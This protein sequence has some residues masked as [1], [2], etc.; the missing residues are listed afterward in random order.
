MSLQVLVAF[1][2][3]KP[4][5]ITSEA[6]SS[7]L[8]AEIDGRSVTILTPKLNWGWM[9]FPK[10]EAP[11]EFVGTPADQYQVPG[12][13][14]EWG[15]VL[16][17][18]P[19]NRTVDAL[20]LQQV[21]VGIVDSSLGGL[22]VLG[23]RAFVLN[24]WLNHEL[25]PW[26]LALSDWIEIWTDRVGSSQARNHR[27][28]SFGHG[29]AT[30]IRKCGVWEGPIRT[31]EQSAA[32]PMADSIWG[33]PAD[34]A[35]IQRALDLVSGGKIPDV[36]DLFRRDAREGWVAGKNR[37]AVLDAGLASEL[38]LYETYKKVLA[39][40][41]SMA[42]RRMPNRD[43]PTLGDLVRLLGA[44][45]VDLP[46]ELKTRLVDPRNDATHR[47]NQTSEQDA[48]QVLVATAEIFRMFRGA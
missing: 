9:G 45:Q 43:R 22:K 16:A 47:S 8:A 14:S 12:R 41:T 30:W 32:V 29:V 36:K 18:N 28:P 46:P 42:E 44:A 35:H 5:R 34:L 15:H 19:S 11:D 21:G 48:S 40:P 33:I 4:I 31:L 39:N 25:P 3:P 6:L 23:E 20:E 24:E 7:S 37:K 27:M 1:D 10:L 17:Y 13:N 38:V 26:F 2:L